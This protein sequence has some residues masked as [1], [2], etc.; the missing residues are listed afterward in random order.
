[1]ALLT[2]A[3]VV[4]RVGCE[5]AV[6]CV[7][8]GVDILILLQFPCGNRSELWA[9]KKVAN[10]PQFLLCIALLQ[11]YRTFVGQVIKGNVTA[12]SVIRLSGYT[13]SIVT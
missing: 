7:S 2:W 5:A 13:Q 1:M 4:V 8:T 10:I 12:H 11:K 6:G 3:L 9:L